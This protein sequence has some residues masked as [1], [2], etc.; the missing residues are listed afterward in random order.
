MKPKSVDQNL[1]Y[2]TLEFVG[3]QPHKGQNKTAIRTRISLE[4][5]IVQKAV[6]ITLLLNPNTDLETEAAR[7]TQ[8]PT[9]EKEMIFPRQL[10]Y[11]RQQLPRTDIEIRCY[12]NK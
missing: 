5:T 2:F 3:K 8:T 10:W 7:N 1:F 9:Q 4:C 6:R 12:R 11:F